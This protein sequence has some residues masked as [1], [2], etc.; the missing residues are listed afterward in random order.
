MDTEARKDPA[1]IPATGNR[2]ACTPGWL[3]AIAP[4]STLDH[5]AGD[6]HRLGESKQADNDHEVYAGTNARGRNDT[7]ESGAMS[8]NRHL[9]PR[10]S[11]RRADCADQL[12]AH[13]PDHDCRAD[14]YR[15]TR[16]VDRGDRDKGTCNDARG[17]NPHR[18]KWQARENGHSLDG[19]GNKPPVSPAIRPADGKMQPSL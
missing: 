13:R 8:K 11:S 10:A 14:A 7:R 2:F 4:A 5:G 15:A 17:G 18:S 12:W 9:Q 3:L 6:S 16:V 1:T 19:E